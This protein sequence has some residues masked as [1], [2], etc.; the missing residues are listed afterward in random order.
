MRYEPDDYFIFVVD[1]EQYAGNF[2]REMTAYCTGVIGEC[3][4]GD[5]HAKQFKEACPEMM[6]LMDE[7][8]AS[9]PDEHGCYRPASIYATPG[10][11]NDGHGNEY[12]DSEWGAQHTIDKCRESIR[13]YQ[14]ERGGLKYVDA[15]TATPNKCSSYQSV[16]MFFNERP[17]IKTLGFLMDRAKKF[18]ELYEKNITITG[19]RL[20]KE[21]VVAKELWKSQ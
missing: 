20:I 17:S 21:E 8:V 4:N 6:S 11:W 2:E 5:E 15:E 14:I 9:V 3:G 18:T 10:W 16:A 13:E 1:T 7:I 19:F 12:P